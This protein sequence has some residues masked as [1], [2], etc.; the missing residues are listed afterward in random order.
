M[1]FRHHNFSHCTCIPSVL[2]PSWRA[3]AGI[4]RGDSDHDPVIIFFLHFTCV[5]SV[6]VPSVFDPLRGMCVQVFFRGVS[7]DVLS[8]ALRRKPPQEEGFTEKHRARGPPFHRVPHRVRRH[9]SK[10]SHPLPSCALFNFL[11]I[12]VNCPSWRVRA[13]ILLRRF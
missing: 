7:D 4:L 13:G 11:F 6:F 5:P 12:V 2:T 1:T 8:I 9:D 10:A 3:C